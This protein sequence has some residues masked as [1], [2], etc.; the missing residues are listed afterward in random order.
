MSQNESWGKAEAVEDPTFFVLGHS[1]SPSQ[2]YTT[3]STWE[4]GWA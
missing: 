2:E 4:D 1:G 3:L